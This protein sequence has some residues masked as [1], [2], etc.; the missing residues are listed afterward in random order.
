MRK[1]GA[2]RPTAH[3]TRCAKSLSKAA[4]S[5]S[6][7]SELCLEFTGKAEPLTDRA[8]QMRRFAL[9]ENLA[10][11]RKLLADETR[12]SRRR[13]LR[14]LLCSA[15]RELALVESSFPYIGVRSG[16][17]APGNRGG[18]SISR[19]QFDFE[20]SQCPYLVLDPRAGL[21]IVD[22]NDAYAG[23]TM[24]TRVSVA[25]ERLFDVFPDNPEDLFAD[26]VSM[27]KCGNKKAD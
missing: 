11:Y 2:S 5:G 14:S 9:K 1:G 16:L 25:G 17:S 13:T 10:L 3:K 22:I 7:R 27:G 8:N 18:Y 12:E 4:R 15:Q 19:F 24:T 21:H 6:G 23:V 26:G 20:T